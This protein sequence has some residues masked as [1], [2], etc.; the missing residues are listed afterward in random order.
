MVLT[1][2]PARVPEMD[3]MLESS[4]ALV[5]FLTTVPAMDQKVGILREN[6]IGFLMMF[7]RRVGCKNL[8]GL[9]Q[10]LAQ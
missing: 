7:L 10:V 5:M 6:C 2:A 9:L 8:Q 3:R 1:M 4:K